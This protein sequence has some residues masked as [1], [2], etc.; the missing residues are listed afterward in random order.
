MLLGLVLGSTQSL[1]RS[2]FADMVPAG[3]ESEYFGF[4]S[5][6]GRFSAALGPLAFGAVSAI[7]GSQRAAMLSLSVFLIAGTWCLVRTRRA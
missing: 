7:S 5:L 6:V 2:L 4:H 1:F 3:R